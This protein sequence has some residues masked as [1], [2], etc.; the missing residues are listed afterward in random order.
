MSTPNPQR[1]RAV[2]AARQPHNQPE[3]FR[4]TLAPALPG[5]APMAPIAPSVRL[6]DGAMRALLYGVWAAA[7][8]MAGTAVGLMV[9]GSLP[10]PVSTPAYPVAQS[11]VKVLP[12]AAAATLAVAKPATTQTLGRTTSAIAVQQATAGTPVSMA[13]GGLIQG[14]GDTQN[15]QPGYTSTGSIQGNRGTDPVSAE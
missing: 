2:R 4:E 3:P 1:G 11:A 8:V 13:G 12:Q 6:S 5:T 15:L 14:T 7:A 10:A 9:I